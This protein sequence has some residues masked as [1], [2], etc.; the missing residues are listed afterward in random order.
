MYEIKRDQKTISVKT[1]Y[2]PAFS[3][4]ARDLGGKWAAPYWVFD[5]RE[6]S[7]VLHLVDEIFG[8]QPGCQMVDV[9]IQKPALDGQAQREAEY[10]GGRMVCRV[11]SKQDSRAKLG[12]GV[13]IVTGSASGGG[14]AKNFFTWIQDGTVFKVRDFPLPMALRLM[15][16]Y[17]E[18]VKIVR[19]YDP[20]SEPVAQADS[21]DP[22]VQALKAKRA[23]LLE[24]IVKIDAALEKLS[25]PKAGEVDASLRDDD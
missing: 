14:S 7:A 6:E 19:G 15:E 20:E 21:D 16:Q 3:P 4:A 11:F 23:A 2:Y 9:K 8:W 13:V 22:E 1:P 5:I 10:F 25:M 12:D 24:E 17:P 18:F